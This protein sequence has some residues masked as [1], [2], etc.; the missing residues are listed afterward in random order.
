M[1]CE[2]PEASYIL[3]DILWLTCRFTSRRSDISPLY[4]RSF[5]FHRIFYRS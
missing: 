4:A 2:P 1:D 5:P 3:T